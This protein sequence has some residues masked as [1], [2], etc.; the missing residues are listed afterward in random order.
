M[1]DYLYNILARS[2]GLIETA[3][4]L[5]TSLFEPPRDFKP[6][7]VLQTSAPAEESAHASDP[8]VASVP[9]VASVSD[10]QDA[11]VEPT[12]TPVL[13]S[14]SVMNVPAAFSQAAPLPA[15]L[16]SE[17]RPPFNSRERAREKASEQPTARLNQAPPAAQII[18]TPER[19]PFELPDSALESPAHA[20][21]KKES[22]AEA[23]TMTGEK[24]RERREPVTQ[25]PHTPE[26]VATH[27]AV[28]RPLSQELAP[29]PSVEIN[30]VTH[31]RSET[32]LVQPQVSR[33]VELQPADSRQSTRANEA[34]ERTVQVTIGRIEVRAAPPASARPGTQTRSAPQPSQSLE[35][36][37]RQRARGNGSR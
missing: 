27:K 29:S 3:Q 36:Y 33:Y 5:V 9:P 21:R 14:S 37:L 30:N 17:S 12:Q 26:L 18:R 13:N 6:V 2:L 15:P 1:S 31:Q 25:R 35:E 32:V 28:E 23:Q 22:S 19:A 16:T 7:D 11:P 24:V 4:P 8:V 10:H 34:A 20:S